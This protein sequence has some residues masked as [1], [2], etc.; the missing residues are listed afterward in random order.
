V[1]DIVIWG[2][3]DTPCATV[4]VHPPETFANVS[5]SFAVDVVINDAVDLGAFQ[6]D[7][8]YNST[9]VNATGA[10]LGPFLGS[11][12]RGVAEVGPSFGS[13][14]VT[15]GAY[16]W[17]S[18]AGPIGNGV[19]ATVTFQAGSNECDSDLILQNVSVTDTSGSA[20]C[21]NAQDGI[22]HVT[23]AV[24]PCNDCPEDINCDG[25]IDIQDIML[26]AGKWGQFC[27]TLP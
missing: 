23:P 11:T 27:P 22:V 12:G 10:T 25:K 6:F 24:C 21:Y 19:L 3:T 7:L 26:V 13:E 9:C 5:S 18:S 8:T 1:D 15:Y 17:G 4:A 2:K 16:S 20:Q 14:S